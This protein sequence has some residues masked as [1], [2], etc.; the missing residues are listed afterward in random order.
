MDRRGYP[1]LVQGKVRRLLVPL[2]TVGALT[3]AM[4]LAAPGVHRRPDPADAWRL[5]VF[6]F[7]HL[8]FL[9]SIFLIFA[10]VGLLDAVGA[11][12]RLAHWS[13]VFAA[14]CVLHVVVAL[15]DG[16]DLFSINRFARLL[17]FFLVGMALHRFAAVLDQR[18]WLAWS[19]TVFAV[20]YGLRLSAILT[21]ADVPFFGAR[22]LSLGVGLTGLVSLFLLRRAL[23]STALAW[24]GTFAFG[25]SSSTS[26]ELP[27]PASCCSGSGSRPTPSSS[28]SECWPASACR[29]CSSGPSGDTRW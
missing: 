23:T 17:P 15:P 4:K 12:S 7:E 29:S 24:L 21:G 11:L 16:A 28:P 18:R 26:S 19:L 25:V 13:A 2:L 9:Q 20:V 22:V 14:A 27:A 8:W 6:P 10:L 1:P 5:L 3:F